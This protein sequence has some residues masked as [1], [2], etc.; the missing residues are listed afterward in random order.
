MKQEEIHITR[1]S[2]KIKRRKTAWNLGIS[3]FRASMGWCTGMFQNGGI[4]ASLKL[5]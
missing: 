5:H 4:S 1:E 3:K 2:I